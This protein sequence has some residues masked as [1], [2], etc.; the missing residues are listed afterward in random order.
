MLKDLPP[1]RTLE[2]VSFQREL[3][4]EELKSWFRVAGK[5]RKV[6]LGKQDAMVGGEK[7]RVYFGLVVYKN[8]KD[9]QM[10]FTPD[11]V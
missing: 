5:I 2:V 1:K 9:L 3:G 4:E 10:A 11:L 6:V 7:K 8:E